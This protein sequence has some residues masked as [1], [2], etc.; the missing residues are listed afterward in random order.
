M[1]RPTITSDDSA[2]LDLARGT[3]VFK[4]LEITALAEVLADYHATNKALGHVC[5]TCDEGG[6]IVGFAYFAPAAMTEG[7]WYLYWIAVARHVQATG[8]GGRMLRFAEEDIANRGGR[9]LLI[10]TSSL[11]HY[12]LTRRFYLKHGY[13]H[14]ATVPEYYAAGD[15]MVVFRK[16]LNN[17]S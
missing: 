16:K 13:D 14:A 17:Q 11:P 8:L 6:Q 3:G 9:H 5:V 1:I 15:D 12:E 2:L 4:P 10:E 7:T